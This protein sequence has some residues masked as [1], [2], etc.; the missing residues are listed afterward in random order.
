VIESAV[1]PGNENPAKFARSRPQEAGRVIEPGR[2]VV[3]HDPKRRGLSVSVIA[4]KTGL[5]RKTVRK[6]PGRGLKAPTY[7]PRTPRP[8]KGRSPPRRSTGPHSSSAHSVARSCI[9]SGIIGADARNASHGRN[10]C[11]RVF[12]PSAQRLR[13]F[14]EDRRDRHCLPQ[15]GAIPPEARGLQPPI[16]STFA[17]LRDH[18][19]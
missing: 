8:R 19:S 18:S 1:S 5:D 10:Q 16:P 17:G 11:P 13:T 12:E 2:V 9:Q 14:S 4:R 3:I 15:A 7:K 6:H